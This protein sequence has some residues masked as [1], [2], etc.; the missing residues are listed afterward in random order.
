MKVAVFG[1]TGGTGRAV[2][3]TLLAAGHRVTA[4]AR[5][6]ARLAAAPGLSVLAGDVMNPADVAPAI[7]GQDG[8]VISLGNSQ[9]ALALR[10]GA[11]RHTPPDVC[12]V[13]TRHIIAAMQAAS[14]AR[15]VCV[16]AF[17]V[18]DTR[19]ILPPMYRLFYRLL[20]SEHMAD[21]EKQESLIK[22]S[23]LEWTL[24]QPVGLT[25]G[26][27]TGR[28]LASATGEVRQQ[29]VSREDL[30]ACI[31]AALLENRYPRQSVTFSG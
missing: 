22:A 3:R 12:E 14:V 15:L 19:D 8:V 10:L 26:P 20:L 9:N 31:V 18:G 28:W 13:G 2:I 5:N 23:G 1:A 16:T 25:N 11:K 17:G 6:P 21:K 27:A 4:L 7:A 24:V 30:A 29:R